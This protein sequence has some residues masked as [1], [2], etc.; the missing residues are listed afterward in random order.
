M[1][2]IL[3]LISVCM[4]FVAGCANTPVFLNDPTDFYFAIS[5]D[6]IPGQFAQSFTAH[7][8]DVDNS[9]SREDIWEGGG[10]MVYLTTA[11]KYNISSTSTND[12][13]TGTGGRTL[14]VVG[15]NA[16]FDFVTE[17]LVLD[18]T[19]TVQTVNEYIRPRTISV[20][21]AGS[22]EFNVGII[23]ATSAVTGDVQLVMDAEEGTSKNTHFTVPRGHQG[24]LKQVIFSATKSGGQAPIVEFKGKIRFNLFENASWIETFDLKIDTSV[25]DHIDLNQ[26]TPNSLPE[27]TDFR[28]EVTTSHDNVDVNARIYF[29]FIENGV[30][31]FE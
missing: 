5:A 19:N 31:V 10:E 20:I 28:I 30:A 7:N 4:L 14:F 24:F 1:K 27:K 18:G 21:T 9:G 11:Q 25:N 23:T 17:F 15:L 3:L 22:E 29:I 8:P 12:T 16:S 6:E 2:K 13:L 26:I